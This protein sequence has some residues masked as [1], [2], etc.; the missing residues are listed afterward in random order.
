MSILSTVFL[1][2]AAAVLII[3]YVLPRKLRPYVLLAGSIVFICCGGWRS[4]VHLTA[5]ALLLWL[6]GM[7]LDAL[8]AREAALW[9]VGG[10]EE[11]ALAR[12]CE[13]E[14]KA[15][16]AVLLILDLGT[17]ILLKFEPAIASWLNDLQNGR[18][19]ILPVWTLAVPLGLSY[20]TFQ[21]AGMLI[22]VSRGKA[23]APR[24]PL[25]AWLFVGYF[26]QLV[27]GPIS[28]W[29]ELGETLWEGR[30]QTQEGF[31]SGFQL[32]LWGYFKKLVIADRLAAV[33]NALLAPAAYM[34]GWLALGGTVLYAVRLY[35]D[36]S[37]GMDVI[38]GFSRMLGIE[39]AE[40][41]RRPFFSLSVA[42]YW[43]R[44]HITLGRWF[45]TYLLYPLANSRTGL[46]LGRSAAKTFGKKTG[47]IIPTAL[48]TFLVFLLIGLWHGAN[49]NAVIYGA[50]FGIIMA[51]SVLMDPVWKRL[52]KMLRK[53]KSV[54]MNLFRMVR[55]WFFVLLPQFFAF[56]PGPEKGFYLMRR[57]LQNW[58]FADFGELVTEIMEVREWIVAGIGLVLLL[59]VDILCE[60]G[61]DV[62][63]RLA[64]ARIWVRWPLLLALM[65]AVLIF[66]IY[67]SGFDASAF[68][69]M[70]F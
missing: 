12:R 19:L 17:M 25:K 44:W 68:L 20:F 3:Y 26:P 67:G 60:R 15:L 64:E 46:A 47:F 32:V 7:G 8:R 58:N 31:V 57:S 36:F 28:T 56:T 42:E 55:T 66:G 41:F 40:N 33:T 2:F 30:P 16:L 49:W 39:L 38:R 53:P 9:E 13:K 23:K 34:P 5:V 29:K 22:D 61:F 50:Y 62:G 18:G 6:G 24:N 21:T 11:K 43:R 51:V 48:G 59:T 65:L 52:N 4:A 54:W 27:Q 14:R 35:A 45:R 10:E 37:G 69:Y 63:G 70:Q 1:F